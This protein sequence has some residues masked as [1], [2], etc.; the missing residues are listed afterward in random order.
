MKWSRSL[1]DLRDVAFV[2]PSGKK[3]G[4]GGVTE[5]FIAPTV[6]PE[7]APVPVP[8]PPAPAPAPPRYGRTGDSVARTLCTDMHTLAL[9]QCSVMI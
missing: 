3:G 8:T 4:G 9:C 5:I 2:K 6:V 7:P 1:Q